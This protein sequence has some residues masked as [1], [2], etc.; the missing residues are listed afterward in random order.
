MQEIWWKGCLGSCWSNSL[1]VF[2]PT[3]LLW[4]VNCQ[5]T[6]VEDI[7][8]QTHHAEENLSLWSLNSGEMRRPSPS[9]WPSDCRDKSSTVRHR[10]QRSKV[11][12]EAAEIK[13]R[14]YKRCCRSKVRRRCQKS[15]VKCRCQRSKVR[16]RCWKSK[17]RRR[18]QRSSEVRNWTRTWETVQA[19]LP[20]CKQA[21]RGRD[22]GRD[23]M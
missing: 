7:F 21:G 11:K 22:G 5:K 6:I 9:D 19:G 2:T 16:R 1:Q 20:S 17:V 10:R 15:E 13:G 12:T 3:H 4:P 23:R 18:C 14:M 8:K